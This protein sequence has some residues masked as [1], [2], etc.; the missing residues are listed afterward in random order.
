MRK[1]LLLI[2]VLSI[3]V[4]SLLVGCGQGQSTPSLT[5][6]STGGGNVSVMKAGT[7]TWIEAEVEMSLEPGDTIRSGDNSSA[8]ITFL[9]GSTIELQA[10]TEIEVASLDYSA[11][12]GSATVVVKQTIGSIIFRV[13]K[14]VDPASRYEV[15]TPAGVVA[16]R[17]SAVQITVIEDGTTWACNLEGDIWAI[18][19]GVELQIPEGRCCVIRPGQP[20]KLV[21]DLTISSTTGGSVTIPGEGTFPYDQ[22]TVVDLTAEAEEGYQF[23]SWTG[24]VGTIGNLNA[25]STAITVDDN[26][27]IIA[28]FEAIPPVQYSLTISRTGGG[29]VT[30]PGDGTFTYEAGTVVSLVAAP[31]SGYYFVNW[32]GDVG[33]IYNLNAASTTITMNGDYSITANFGVIP[34]TLLSPPVGSTGVPITNVYFSWTPAGAD[35]YDWV[36]DDDSDFSSPIEFKTGLT[37]PACM[38][39]G[40]L[41]YSTPYYWMVSAYRDGTPIDMAVGTFTTVPMP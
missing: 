3:L 13:T 4:A 31:Y 17:G 6:F 27:S 18:A 11:D 5:I 29:L 39:T 34:L 19:Q 2:V 24:D 20:P 40:P 7:N 35:E 26:Y 16:V 15:E 41:A 9:D 36:L 38:H 37:T 32:T 21:C 33:T 25:T 30:V 8:E 28:N 10:S 23:G 1:N 14:I 22:G 12:T